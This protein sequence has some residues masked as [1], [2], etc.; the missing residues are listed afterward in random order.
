MDIQEITLDKGTTTSIHGHIFGLDYIIEEEDYSVKVF[1]DSHNKRIVVQDYSGPNI[2]N[3]SHRLDYLARENDF[4]KV[5]IKAKM[6]DWED[7][8]THGYLLEGVFKY[9]YSGETAYSIA[10]FYS[11]DRRYSEKIEKENEIIK[12]IVH[13]DPSKLEIEPELSEGL[14][15]RTATTD[16][17]PKIVQLY[18]EVFKSYPTPLNKMSYVSTLMEYHDVLFKLILDGDR[19]V[20]AASADMD[21][22]NKNAEMTD[23]ATDPQYRGSGFMS[24]LMRELEKEIKAKG[25]ITAYSL[26]RAQSFGMNNV[27]YRL[28]YRYNGRLINNCDIMGSFEDMNLWVKKIN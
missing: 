18:D 23:C 27:F 11:K 10:K 14:V 4:D 3:L 1:I 28:G 16:D 21:I 9:Y 20:S 25:I 26:A 8:I 19:I 13:Q 2:H 12:K 5:F 22:K 17:I 15:M 6:D 24:I 7:F